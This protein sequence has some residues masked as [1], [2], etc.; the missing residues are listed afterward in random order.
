M[1]AT[2]APSGPYVGLIL[3]LT[4]NGLAVSSYP[5]MVTVAQTAEQYGFDSVWLC[6]HFLTI[7]PDDYVK[8]AGITTGPRAARPHRPGR[9]P[10]W[11][12]GPR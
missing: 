8:D 5:D 11:K 4:V 6:D 1:N 10:C 9:C 7:S 2:P 3:A 12:A